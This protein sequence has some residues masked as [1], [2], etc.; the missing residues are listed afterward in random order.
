[1][2]SLLEFDTYLLYYHGN[3]SNIA[4]LHFQIKTSIASLLTPP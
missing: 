1:M 3:N 2:K 4:L